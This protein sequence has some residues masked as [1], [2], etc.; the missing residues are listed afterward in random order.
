MSDAE[1]LFGLPVAASRP[2]S[3]REQQHRGQDEWLTP[4]H[5]I[6]ALGPFDLDPC[7]PRVRPWPTAD[8]H[9]SV[10]DDGLRQD[11]RGMVWLNP[12]YSTTTRWVARL[13]SHGDGIAL[14]FARTETAMWHDH[15][16]PH[17]TC[18]LFLRGRIKFHRSDGREAAVGAGAPSA[19]IAYGERAA[20]R[21]A[22]C[23]LVGQIVTPVRPVEPDLF[24]GN[25]DLDAAGIDGVDDDEV[26]AFLSLIRGEDAG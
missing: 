5:I 9:Y 12:P 25:V 24:R 22:S 13:A 1:D 26:T 6:T 8:R 14:L 7:A 18:L 2:N 19:L 10:Q 15:I 23:G 16:W 21:L 17:A 3:V 4:P 20:E 11:W